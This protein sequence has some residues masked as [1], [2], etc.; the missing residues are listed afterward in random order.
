MTSSRV[1]LIPVALVA[2]AILLPAAAGAQTRYCSC[3]GYGTN[4]S[5]CFYVVDQAARCGG[6]RTGSVHYCGCASEA[7]DGSGGCSRLSSR[8]T[9]MGSD[10]GGA[11]LDGPQLGF[12]LLNP[13]NGGR[14]PSTSRNGHS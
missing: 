14:G 8:T 9:M 12:G 10:R 13:G 5:A 3:N 6:Y 11:K 1:R 2:L 7:I 4:C